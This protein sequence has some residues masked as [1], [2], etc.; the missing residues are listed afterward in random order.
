MV[1]MMVVIHTHTHTHMYTHIYT[2]IHTNIYTHTHSAGVSIFFTGC[3]GTGKSL[4]LKHVIAA[5]PAATTFFTAPTGMCVVCVCG[6]DGV[7]VCGTWCGCVL[8]YMH[9]TY[10]T[11]IPTP[12]SQH[13]NPPTPPPPPTHPLFQRP[14]SKCT[15]GHHHQ[16]LCW[17]RPG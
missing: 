14:G 11:S 13:T 2:C 9:Y 10:N 6:H 8:I 16:R 7:Y 1:V 15:R 5:L 3:A 17:H 12:S 4:V